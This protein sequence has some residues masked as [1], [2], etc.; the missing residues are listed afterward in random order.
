MVV[1]NLNKHQNIKCKLFKHIAFK[2]LWFVDRASL[3]NLVIKT[4]LVHSLFLLYLSMFR[5]TMG[6]SSGE[7]AVFMRRLVLV[8][9]CG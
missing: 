6:P 8:I 4:K 5:A 1:W 3:Y 9:L 2:I 7:T